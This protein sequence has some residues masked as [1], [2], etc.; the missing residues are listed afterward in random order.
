MPLSIA[1]LGNF[2]QP[3]CTEVHVA[4]SLEE[5]GHKV[6]RLQESDV[7]LRAIDEG[8]WGADLFLWTRTDGFLK[9]SSAEMLAWL[10]SKRVLGLPTAS[11][12]LDLYA[13][14]SRRT[15]ALEADPFWRTEHVF[16]PDGGSPRFF[17][18]HGVNHHYLRPGVY[19]AECVSGEFN[20]ELAADVT[21]VGSGSA[22]GSYHAE[23]VYRRELLAWL[24]KTYG[25]RFVKHGNPPSARGRSFIRGR[26]LSDLYASARVVV[27]DTL[28]LGPEDATEPR[29]THA[30]YWSD[31]VYETVGRG[32]FLIHP[33]IAGLDAEFRDGEHLRYYA[34]GDFAALRAIIDHYLDHDDERR[35]IAVAGQAFVRANCTYVYRTAEMLRILAERSASIAEALEA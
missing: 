20:R 12:H 14:L 2:S 24:A 33:R 6:A 35:R 28:C 29:F 1:Y 10:A 16:T 30:G 11:F 17:E 23:W 3:H 21:F 22:H 26:D 5:Q 27:G 32:G 4:A 8:T 15:G 18:R 25:P 34:Y 13:G 7:S 19:G 9:A 31:R